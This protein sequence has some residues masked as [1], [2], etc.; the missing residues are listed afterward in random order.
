M[1]LAVDHERAQL[2][3][4]CEIERQSTRR[5]LRDALDLPDVDIR[6][7]GRM[8][9]KDL[10]LA[11][12]IYEER[13]DSDMLKALASANGEV[14]GFLRVSGHTA[15]SSS[16]DA[17][18][19]RLI[20]LSDATVPPEKVEAAEAALKRR[21]A[22]AAAEPKVTLEWALG[23][24]P[25]GFPVDPPVEVPPAD[26]GESPSLRRGVRVSASDEVILPP[27]PPSVVVDTTSDAEFVI[28]PKS[29]KRPRKPKSPLP[30]L[31]EGIPEPIPGDR[32]VW[33]S[34][35]LMLFSGGWSRHQVEE[36]F[37]GRS[38]KVLRKDVV[39]WFMKFK[40]PGRTPLDVEL[41]GPGDG[42]E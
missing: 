27:P 24:A 39:R 15:K 30:P 37:A 6:A 32:F 35:A 4:R 2:L 36:F 7:V 22:E 18:F 8:L 19:A 26:S 23:D 9:A 41:K 12:E 42:R 21:A 40:A 20:D 11:T 10:V 13:R 25:Q 34:V 33:R 38:I 5:E 29:S 16:A 3:D 1:E 28:K 31:P 17:E 14:L